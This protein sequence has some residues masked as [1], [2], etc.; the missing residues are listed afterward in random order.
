[1]S[2]L[3]LLRQRA[4]SL[5]GRQLQVLRVLSGGQHAVTLLVSD[6]DREL[7]VRGFPSGDTAVAREVA[8]LPVIAPLGEW[9]PQLVAHST[10]PEA[11]LIATTRVPGG[12][13]DPDLAVHDM[14]EQL[15][16]ALAR[17]HA[18]PQEGASN[19]TPPV[20]PDRVCRLVRDGW[21]ALAEEPPVL[22]HHDFWCGN[23]LWAGSRLTGVVDWSSARPAP[24]G[25]DVAWCRQDLVLLGSPSAA[26]TFVTAYERAA[27]LAVAN[28]RLW[29]LHAAAY[30][31]NAV[32]S[33]A[34]NYVGIGRA[35]TPADL[36]RRLDDWI[37]ALLHAT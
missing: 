7:V 20:G 22:A 24:R 10:D 35:I 31:R 17:V 37:T 23:A 26:Q 27:G 13:P 29:D 34:P 32:E 9:V 3:D 18:L 36:R 12:H 4:E 15:G 19:L 28:L 14:A 6:G 11:P 16:Q 25:V 33:W 21:S 5:L 8:V 30:A 1:M 2:E